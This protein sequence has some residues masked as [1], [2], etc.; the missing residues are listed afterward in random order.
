LSYIPLRG[1]RSRLG[2]RRS[3]EKERRWWA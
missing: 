2:S 3:A 1:V